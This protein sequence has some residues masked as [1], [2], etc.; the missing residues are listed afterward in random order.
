MAVATLVLISGCAAKTWGLGGTGENS[1][2]RQADGLMGEETMTVT[3]K[4]FLFGITWAAVA[5]WA[6]AHA[7]TF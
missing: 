5:G 1:K 6:T 4:L 7:V 3:T 2:P